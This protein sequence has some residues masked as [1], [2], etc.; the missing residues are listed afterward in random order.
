MAYSKRKGMQSTT[1]NSIPVFVVIAIN[2]IVNKIGIPMDF[3][4]MNAFLLLVASAFYWVKN[5]LKNKNKL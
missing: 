3:E 1:V 2:Y 4:T 5:Y